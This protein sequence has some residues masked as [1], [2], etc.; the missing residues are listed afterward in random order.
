MIVT[1][2][3]SQQI[4]E[5]LGAILHRNVNIMNADG[6]IVASTDPERIDTLHQAAKE[7]IAQNAPEMDVYSCDRLSGSREGI[8]LP[9]R[10]K[11]QT[12]GVI[13]ITGNPDE[14]RDIG[15]VIMEMAEILFTETFQGQER[16]RAA[17]QQRHYLETLLFSS[18]SAL[19]ESF[20]RHGET[21]GVEAGRIKAVAVLSYPAELPDARRAVTYDILLSCLREHLSAHVFLYHHHLGEKLILC[22][23]MD[24]KGY[25]LGQMDGAVR[26]ARE[27]SGVGIYCGLS[28]GCQSPLE[29]HRVYKQAEKAF[30]VA[31]SSEL[32]EVCLYESLALE[33]LLAQL[34]REDKSAF[35]NRVWPGV[36]EG[37]RQGMTEFLS[38]YFECDGSIQRLAARLFI[39]KNTVQYKIRKIADLTGYDPRRTADA[40]I[41]YLAVKIGQTI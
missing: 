27:R 16:D 29:I 32:C 11:G 36:N 8:N 21:I 17:R 10:I 33:L 38:A 39:H 31:R 41:L 37:E 5:R 26:E 9:L 4:A 7:L 13:G 15:L 6:V 3:N 14:L 30:Q 35:V 18:P 40:A 22:L 20:L 34:S 2:A 28:G 12:V 25:L 23:G 1:K 24:A 19:S